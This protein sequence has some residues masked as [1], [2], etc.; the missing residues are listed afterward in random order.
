MNQLQLRFGLG[1][2]LRHSHFGFL[3]S[4]ILLFFPRLYLRLARDIL[5]KA[6]EISEKT[7]G[8]WSNTPEA[9]LL[10]IKRVPLEAVDLPFGPLDMFFFLG[11]ALSVLYVLT[12][13]V[14]VSRIGYDAQA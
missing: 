7:F 13:G 9:I 10:P 2:S 14:D 1:N 3:G 12:Q 4:L 11:Y 6:F 5:P 8:H